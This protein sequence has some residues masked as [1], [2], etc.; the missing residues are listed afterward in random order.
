MRGRIFS[1][2]TYCTL[3]A[4]LG[5]TVLINFYA[6]GSEAHVLSLMLTLLLVLAVFF[7]EFR[8]A[9]WKMLLSSYESFQNISGMG[10]VMTDSRGHILHQI[11]AID[12][13]QMVDLNVISAETCKITDS[14][15]RLKDIEYR[16][17]TYAL[18]R[19]NFRNGKAVTACFDNN[20][21]ARR[22]RLEMQ[23]SKM[24]AVS[25]LAAGVAHDFNNILSI[26]DGY[27]HLLGQK[28][29]KNDN[30]V[31]VDYVGR[32]RAAVARG[33]SLTQQI[34]TL[35]RQKMQSNTIV[36]AVEAVEQQLPMLKTV[37]GPRVQLN[38]HK[39]G[40]ELFFKGPA[41]ALSQILINL[42]RNA[43]DAMNSAGE[44]EI[45]LTRQDD[46]EMTDGTRRDVLMLRF[47]DDG[48]GMDTETLNK[49]F[50]PFFTTK[51]PGKGTG[52]G[53]AMVYGLVRQMRGSINVYSRP[54]EGTSFTML[55]PLTDE[56]PKF[57]AIAVEDDP[58]KV[59]FSGVSVLVVDDERDLCEILCSSLTDKGFEVTTA[60]CGNEALVHVDEREEPY[61]FLLSDI[62]MPDIDGARLADL[63]SEVSPTTQIVFLSG[64]PKSHYADRPTLQKWP[65]LMKPVSL[66]DLLALLSEMITLR[67]ENRKAD[68]LKTVASMNSWET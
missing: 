60:A 24:E 58:E 36:N 30:V 59:D 37:L 15:V 31:I 17:K 26:I 57:H 63:V 52:L 7:K 38:F 39:E 50:D 61:D 10:M 47:A 49:V 33:N 68:M 64:Y 21:A 43:R 35:G 46:C 14:V 22:Q 8:N 19:Q 5:L 1:I 11:G 29:A 25:V 16:G 54:G 2:L 6:L 42:A 32:I 4:A 44:V 67:V 62:A 20:S 12:P 40:R 9:E 45:A 28:D 53:M 13:L 51:E 27:A 3:L 41:D 18:L 56:R 65:F 48:D 23:S 55:I 34:L 66:P